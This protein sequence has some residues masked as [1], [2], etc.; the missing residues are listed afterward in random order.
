MDITG[1]DEKR[2]YTLCVRTTP[3]GAILPFQQV[4]SG[5]TRGSLPRAN[6][7]GMAEA[8][9]LGFDFAVA[10]SKKKTSHFSTLKTMKEWM[11]NVLKPYISDHIKH[12]GLQDDQKAILLIDCY[13]IHTSKEFRMHVFKEFPN[14]FLLFIPANCNVFFFEMITQNLILWF[15]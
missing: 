1:R 10:D 3:T 2:A 14:V 15:N 13:P 9:E 5:K 11:I 4:W 8:K 7:N 12:N 6:A